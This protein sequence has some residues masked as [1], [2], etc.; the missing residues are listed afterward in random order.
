[1]I[2]VSTCS[3]DL[4]DSGAE[5]GAIRSHIA[6]GIELQE[7]QLSGG[8]AVGKNVVRRRSTKS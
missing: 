8:G 3:A 2:L 6:S 7:P 1:M 4:T 5:A